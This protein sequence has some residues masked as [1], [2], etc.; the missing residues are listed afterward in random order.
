VTAHNSDVIGE[1]ANIDFFAEARL[2]GFG[3][4]GLDLVASTVSVAKT[5][6]RQSQAPRRHK[7]APQSGKRKRR[8][9]K[10]SDST[11]TA[12]ATHKYSTML[13]KVGRN[14]MNSEALNVTVKGHDFQ[15][16]RRRAADRQGQYVSDSRRAE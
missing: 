12:A 7:I 6:D 3:F 11:A 5:K 15:R 13:A 14:P 10:Y 8:N 1:G 4:E 16:G 9:A 2:L